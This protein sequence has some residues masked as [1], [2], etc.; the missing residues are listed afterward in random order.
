MVRRWLA[1]FVVIALIICL[2]SCGGKEAAE[3][4]A[5]R[6]YINH[7]YN[8]EVSYPADCELDLT[9]APKTVCIECRQSPGFVSVSIFTLDMNAE[10]YKGKEPW[11]IA[12][13]GFLDMVVDKFIESLADTWENLTILSN[14]SKPDYLRI[15]EYSYT[16][17]GERFMGLAYFQWRQNAMYNW[18]G[19]AMV[20]FDDELRAIL[21]SF[22][23]IG[24]AYQAATESLLYR[25]S[26]YGYTIE[27][28]R[29]WKIDTTRPKR[30]L[31][32]TS[33]SKGEFAFITISVLTKG[34]LSL[35]EAVE[36]KKWYLVDVTADEWKDLKFIYS[37]SLPIKWDWV[38]GFTYTD[39]FDQVPAAGEVHILQTPEYTFFV[40]WDGVESQTET[41]QQIVESFELSGL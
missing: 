14:I 30:V 15:L 19:S 22:E 10:D 21:D 9:K 35:D 17:H 37:H 32:H 8:Y 36:F 2:I 40:Q 39:I 27:Y 26:E 12:L 13:D 18:E 31:I 5:V 16:F 34:G 33:P 6:D 24:E 23:Y 11:E 41:C 20:G 29:E 28:P 3:Q 25:N 4:P 38:I 7:T 1:L